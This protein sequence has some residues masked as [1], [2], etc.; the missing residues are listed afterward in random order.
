[1]GDSQAKA[2]HDMIFA[3]SS[4]FGNYRSIRPLGQRQVTKITG[5]REPP[6]PYTV[7]PPI[8]YPDMTMR[9]W[10]TKKWAQEA[11]KKS[12]VVADSVRWMDK[13]AR[14]EAEF[15][16]DAFAEDA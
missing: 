9:E 6:S 11:L 3:M 4:N 5:Y 14:A 10:R 8:E 12:K 7:V 2:L 1:M 15:M 16:R 13:H